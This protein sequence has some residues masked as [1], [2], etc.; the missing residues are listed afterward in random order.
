MTKQSFPYTRSD[1]DLIKNSASP[2]S[3][4]LKK[5]TSQA[6]FQHSAKLTFLY[7]LAEHGQLF[8]N[9]QRLKI[10][11]RQLIMVFPQQ[12]FKLTANYQR[13]IQYYQFQFGVN[14]L[15]LTSSAEAMFCQAAL[16]NEILPPCVQLSANEQ[17]QM[18]TLLTL[19]PT[20]NQITLLPFL[21]HFFPLSD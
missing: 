15:I 19:T 2:N 5:A 7:I 12:F 9:D 16:Q 18:E 17:Q 14:E 11:P 8:F 10:K 13:S 6:Q 3:N 4:W 21:L 1:Y 20:A